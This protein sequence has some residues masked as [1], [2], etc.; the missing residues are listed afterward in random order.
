MYN[1]SLY[2]LLRLRMLL[3]LIPCSLYN[4]TKYFDFI[5]YT[6]FINNEIACLVN[7]NR[8]LKSKLK[9][10]T[11]C[12]AMFKAKAG[13][14]L[15]SSGHGRKPSGSNSLALSIQKAITI[16][17]KINLGIIYF[18]KI[19]IVNPRNVNLCSKKCYL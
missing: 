2:N 4:S 10:S 6:I 1:K 18:Y 5:T 12:R 8:A 3:R 14:F 15:N 19:I 16:T 13:I 9:L 11:P 7:S 17:R